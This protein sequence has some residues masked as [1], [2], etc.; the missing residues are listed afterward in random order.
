MRLLVCVVTGAL[1]AAAIGLS[2]APVAAQDREKKEK[3]DKDKVVHP[4]ALLGF[5]E[6][7]EG[8]KG[9]GAKVGDLLFAKLAAK[10]D[11]HL[12]ERADLK[13]VLDEQQLAL[14]GAVKADD[15]AKVGRLT[16][17][18]VLVTGSVVSAD[19]KLYLVAKVMGAETGRVVAASVEGVA[20]DDLGALAGK[21]A[22]ALAAAVADD[23][24]KLVPKPVPAADRIAELDKTLGKGVRPV[25]HVTVTERHI[26]APAVDPAAET[27]L[28]RFARGGGFEVID[29][30][31]AKGSADVVVT[32]EGFSEVAGR[33]GG[34]VSVRARVEIKAVDRK[35]GKVLAAD[36]QTT[37]VVDASEQIAGKTALQN[38]AA[39]IAERLL[40]KLVTPEK[41]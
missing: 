8:V 4:V 37:L 12:V 14:S 33:V 34:L 41:K 3:D 28:L 19:K 6:R 20:S 23:G 32:G 9:V 36:R 27:E 40:P 7:G 26:G 31:G 38:A 10:P 15:A 25:L 30:S 35:T 1:V 29:A 11:V 2:P 16:G 17:A 18:R 5:E 22:D 24:G 13:K 21:L 39:D